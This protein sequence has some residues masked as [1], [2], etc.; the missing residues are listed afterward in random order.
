MTDAG[1]LHPEAP[2]G[3]LPIPAG[4]LD[5]AKKQALNA[6]DTKSTDPSGPRLAAYYDRDGNSAGASFAE[7]TPNDP[8]DLTPADLHAVS[9]M[10]VTI[11]PG[12]TRRFLDP[13]PVRTDLLA[14]LA[15]V[16]Q[17]PLR[18]ARSADLQSMAAF[19]ESVKKHLGDRGV[20]AS[21]RW[22][23]ASKICARKRAYLFPVRDSVI[24]DFLGLSQYA[25]YQVDL[26][27]F[28]ALIADPDI[29]QGCDAA[30]AA[31]HLA[32]G[33]RRLAIDRERLRV[34]D[35]ALWT[36]ALKA[37]RPVSR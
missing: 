20:A 28:R 17:L 6:L 22:V 30:T 37:R 15:A 35:A 16:P 3:W 18:D 24:R 25:S 9:L 26:Q 34:L 27:V 1:V 36:F 32:P 12:A 7:L 11:G 10:S 29:L 13:G 19:Y 5:T 14:A 23:T 8:F 21:D 31:A 33:H 4:A 2:P